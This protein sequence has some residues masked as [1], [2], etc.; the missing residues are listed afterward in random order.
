MHTEGIDRIKPETTTAIVLEKRVTNKDEKHPVKLRITHKR[1]RKYYTLKNE[2]YSIADFEK[3]VNSDSR[4]KNKI[5]RRKFVSVE[6]RAINIIDYVLNDF[7]FDAFEREFKSQKKK[8][9]SISGY[10]EDKAAEL[11]KS[12]KFQTASV[13]RA[14][15]NSLLDFDDKISFDK[16][17]PKYLKEYE[18]YMLEEGNTYTTIGIYLRNLKHIIN[19]GIRDRAISQYP[20]GKEKDKYSIPASKNTKK[21]LT[22]NDIEKIFNYKTEVRN[23]YLAQQYFLFSYLCNGM[24]MVDIANLKYSNIKENNIEFIRQKTKDTTKEI[25]VIKVL[26]LPQVMDIINSIGNE[27]IAPE[28]YIFSIFQKSYSEADKYIKLKQH[29]KNTN[30]YIRIIAAKIGINEAITTY[31]AR[32]TFSTVLKRSGTPIEFISEQLGHQS[33]QVTQSYLDTFEDE[34]RTKYSET[35]IPESIKISPTTDNQE[36]DKAGINT[37]DIP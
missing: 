16:I 1:V 27:N 30:K 20:F 12:N 34:Q 6:N 3:I 32:H 31:W 33:T 22:L 13:Y 8:D 9:S 37:F 26:L 5:K 10:F 35:L 28:N 19:L 14:A 2:S 11:D 25:P 7:S 17:T 4:G 18:I 15:L 24:N 23:E 36:N 29:I 21:A